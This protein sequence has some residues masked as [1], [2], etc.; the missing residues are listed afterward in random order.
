[1]ASP[2]LRKKK[3]KGD[4]SYTVDPSTQHSPFSVINWPSIPE[5][6]LV[7]DLF[8]FAFRLHLIFY[9][10]GG[11]LL[12]YTFPFLYPSPTMS[13]RP[14]NIGIKAIEVYFPSQVCTPEFLHPMQL[15]HSRQ[16]LIHPLVR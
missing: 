1:V 16:K 2:L 12:L 4:R 3:R 13:A 6:T 9:S 7:Q 5:L 15:N 8:S 11:V 10:L 14:Q